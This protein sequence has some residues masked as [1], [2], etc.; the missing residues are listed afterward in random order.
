[1]SENI[2]GINRQ[3]LFLQ[4]GVRKVI[5]VDENGDPVTPEPGTPEVV[6]A[7]PIYVP[8]FNPATD[9]IIFVDRRKLYRDPSRTDQYIVWMVQNAVNMSLFWDSSNAYE[10][11]YGPSDTTKTNFKSVILHGMTSGTCKLSA[12]Y[13]TDGFTNAAITDTIYPFGFPVAED[14]GMDNDMTG[15]VF[16][17]VPVTDIAGNILRKAD[18]NGNF[19]KTR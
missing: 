14:K 8:N 17:T 2:K 7:P 18:T 16:S 1:M 4:S 10:A 9:A 13:T 15:I 5:I 11:K 19:I 3:D 6:N 12:T